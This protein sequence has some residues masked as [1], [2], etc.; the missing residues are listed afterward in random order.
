[1][2][3]PSFQR[4]L[5]SKFHKKYI[6]KLVADHLDTTATYTQ[7]ERE[8]LNVVLHKVSMQKYCSEHGIDPTK[9]LHHVSLP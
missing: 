4:L 9:G 5:V 7:Q 1:M 6:N 8:Q 2:Y 3:I